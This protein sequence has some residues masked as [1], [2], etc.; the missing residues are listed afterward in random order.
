MTVAALIS[1]APVVWTVSTSFK[2]Q[3]EAQEYPP[4][5]WPKHV[6][7]S[8]YTDLLVDPD[9][10]A[11]IWTSVVV[12]V[13]VTVLVLVVAFPCAYALARLRAYG[14]KLVLLFVAL[15]Q[16]VPAIV[17]LIPL[18]SMVVEFHLYDTKTALVLVY[19]GL[20]IPFSTLILMGFIRSVPVEIEDAALV[21]GCGR[22]RVLLWIVLPM[23]RPALATA[24]VFTAISSWNEFLIAAILGGE[25]ARP[26]TV[27]I[28]HFV[29]Q[30]TIL[31][32]PMTAA[33]SLVLLPVVVAVILLQRQLVSGLAA[34][35][36]KG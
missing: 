8:N 18:Y 32:G 35:A 17:V 27:L 10:H 6:K 34:G 24:A 3:L 11:S 9:F 30:K 36:M 19:T 23:T 2:N 1:L 14:S 13:C 16:T 5:L 12:T 22:L 25:K 20:L 7:L 28:S 4:S 26:L 29:S 33:V 31:W 15:A 21:D